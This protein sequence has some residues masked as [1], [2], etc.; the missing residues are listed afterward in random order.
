MYAVTCH[1]GSS[2][3]VIFDPLAYV[4]CCNK[5]LTKVPCL[6]FSISSCGMESAYEHAEA[7]RHRVGTHLQSA[8]SPG[9]QS[10]DEEGHVESSDHPLVGICS[11]VSAERWTHP[12]LDIDSTQDRVAASLEISSWLQCCNPPTLSA[13]PFLLGL[14]L[15][16]S[17]ESL[18][19][20]DLKQKTRSS[21]QH[22]KWQEGQG[23]NSKGSN[24]HTVGTESKDFGGRQ[25]WMAP[26]GS[27]AQEGV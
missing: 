26:G 8:A 25:E 20:E 6:S 1:P 5:K 23:R 27:L 2:C 7:A 15:K 16:A 14:L 21:V 18:S 4:H 22:E 17:T 10:P 11:Q 3:I 12:P 24:R 19:F 9:S 13:E